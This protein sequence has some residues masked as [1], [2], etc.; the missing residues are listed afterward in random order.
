MS[1]RH[2]ID[3]LEK[4]KYSWSESQ[5]DGTQHAALH[6]VE[7][8]FSKHMKF[9]IDESFVEKVASA[10]NHAFDSIHIDFSDARTSFIQELG[11][12]LGVAR[13]ITLLIQESAIEEY[14]KQART[15]TE[16]GSRG[17]PKTE[18]LLG[19]FDNEE[20]LS[21]YDKVCSRFKKF[22]GS[23]KQILCCFFCAVFDT[24][25]TEEPYQ[26]VACYHRIMM[27]HIK[28]KIPCLRTIQ[29]GI[30]WFRS[31]KDSV[32]RWKDKT[33][34]RAKHDVWERLYE[35]IKVYLPQLEPSLAMC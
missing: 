8:I 20:V 11:D 27:D 19:E 28:E 10:I 6:V 4:N 15:D 16:E 24:V 32:L 13:D 31:W 25:C 5:G 34:E 1:R 3:E 7:N 17:K 35:K 9:T 26:K 30:K 22:V 33:K 21:W 23:I 18:R 14:R 2:K 29:N 12:R